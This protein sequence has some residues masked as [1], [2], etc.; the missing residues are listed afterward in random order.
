MKK[1]ILI[2][3]LSGFTHKEIKEFSEY[4]SSPFFNKNQ[5]I[6]KLNN[7]LKLKY[8]LFDKNEIG[9]R[10]VFQE[11]FPKVKYNDGFM[12]TLISGLSALAENFLSYARYKNSYY[13]D[14]TLL[15]YELN[16][17]HLDRH[18]EKNIKLISRKLESEKVRDSEYYLDKYNL[19]NEK[20][21]YYFRKKPDVYEKIV[22]KTKLSEMTDYLSIFYYSCI[23][24]DYTRL[25][26]L[27]NIY[28]FEFDTRRLDKFLGLLTEE[29]LKKT[30][31]VLVSYYELMLFNNKG[32]DSYFYKL[33]EQLELNENILEG[34]H[35]H[36]IY[37]NL[38]NYCN[39][40]IA[41]GHKEF[42]TE[43]FE[44]YRKGLE[45]KS[46]LSV[47]YCISGFIQL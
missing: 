36:N 29:T 31:C 38:I 16:D 35:V 2:E 11:L 46:F 8:P 26:N 20:Y 27:K 23:A 25:C 32:D 42:E 9:K 34:D 44:L 21:L 24:G 17:R 7:H 40:K 28:N 4:V 43:V 15:L 18:L 3:I 39:R 22:K 12:R 45:K 14:K 5:S 1:S 6:I 47:V 19:E 10:K 30:P 41:E 37:I 33:K 13:K